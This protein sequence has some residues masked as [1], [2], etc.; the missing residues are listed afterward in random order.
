M[1]DFTSAYHQH[2]APAQLLVGDAVEIPLFIGVVRLKVLGLAQF[3]TDGN[4][5][6]FVN[7]AAVAPEQTRRGFSVGAD[8]EVGS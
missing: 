5:S 2:T 7:L 3:R 8:V 6:E 4:V 1:A